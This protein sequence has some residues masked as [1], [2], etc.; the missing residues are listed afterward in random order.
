[1]EKRITK[2]ACPCTPQC[3]K[4]DARCQTTCV[5]FKIYRV[6]RERYYEQRLKEAEA[7]AG[8]AE[9]AIH[10]ARRTS[11]PLSRRSIWLQK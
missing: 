3:S 9:S 5:K 7:N 8:I 6:H 4:R 1:M 10:V 11:N 2:P